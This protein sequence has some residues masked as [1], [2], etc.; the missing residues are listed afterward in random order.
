MPLG[1]SIDLFDENAKAGGFMRSQIPAFRLPETV[2]DEEVALVL[3]MGVE[4]LFEQRV[5]SLQEVLQRSYDAVFIGTGAPRGKDLDIP[6]RRE[7]SANVHLGIQW[8]ANVAFEHTESIGRRV[9]VLGG[10]NTAMDCCRTAR[11]LGGEQVSIAVRSTFADMKASPWE[12]EDAKREGI[13]FLT[14]HSP[15]EF[16]C[17]NGRL[18][19]MLFDKVESVYDENGRRKLVPSGEAPVFVEADDVLVAIGQDVAFPWIERDIGIE[20]TDDGL[21]VVDSVSFQSTN[22]KVFFGGDAAFGPENIITAVAHGHQAAISIDMQLR[23]RQ[24]GE[25]AAMNLRTE[26][27]APGTKLISTKMGI[28]QWSYDS[29]VTD[30]SRYL[31]PHL[32]NATALSDRRA[33]VELG[34]DERTAFEEAQ[35]C[36]NCDVQTVFTDKACI[37]CDSCVDVCPTDCITFTKNGDEDDLRS[38]LNAPADDRNQDLYISGELPTGRSM[39][40]DENVCLH[41]GLCAERCPTVAWDMQ[42]FTYNVTKASRLDL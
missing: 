24:D 34:F 31:V 38:R 35:R 42:Q 5:E 2:L 17:E 16:V 14:D 27:P 22:E 32:D 6:G 40:K 25:G 11:R 29:A 8:L 21:P 30:D 18:V 20:F 26:R 3:D 15:K 10:G 28:H 13:P 7:A 4:R 19:G 23:G 37:E 33:E 1:Y 39:V 41:C 12:K 9:I 36:L